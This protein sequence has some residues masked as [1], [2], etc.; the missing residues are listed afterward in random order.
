MLDFF[1]AHFPCPDANFRNSQSVK[2]HLCKAS[3]VFFFC[4]FVCF[5]FTSNHL[6]KALIANSTFFLTNPISISC[7]TRGDGGGSAGLIRLTLGALAANVSVG[8]VIWTGSIVS[9]LSAWQWP[10]GLRFSATRYWHKARAAAWIQ[11]ESNKHNGWNSLI[12]L[13]KELGDQLVLTSGKNFHIFLHKILHSPVYR[14]K[15]V[16]FPL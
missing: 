9:S 6:L 1:M 5:F 12:G 15:N 2:I 8:V 16:A 7:A 10:G 3:N 14:A 13:L 4:L 11:W